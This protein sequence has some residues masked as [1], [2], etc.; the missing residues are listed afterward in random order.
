M[1]DFF[2]KYLTTIPCLLIL[3]ILLL[4]IYLYDTSLDACLPCPKPE[5]AYKDKGDLDPACEKARGLHGKCR[6]NYNTVC[7][8]L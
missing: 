4:Q 8:E 3:L 7:P 6:D 5:L 2:F 1:N